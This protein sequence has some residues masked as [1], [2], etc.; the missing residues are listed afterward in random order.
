MKIDM[1]DESGGNIISIEV[2]RKSNLHRRLR[3]ECTH[4]NVTVDPLLANLV[5]N[6][7]GQALNPVAWIA[8][9]ADHWD[10]IIRL[11]KEYRDAK[12][13]LDEKIR[14]KCQHCGKFTPVRK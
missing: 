8:M 10:R 4:Q 11:S 2:A 7:C 5:C 1:P 13:A 9:L 3:K 12:A 14:T 6:D